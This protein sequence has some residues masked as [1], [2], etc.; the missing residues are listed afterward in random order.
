[1]PRSGFDLIHRE[2]KLA[3]TKALHFFAEVLLEIQPHHKSWDQGTQG[4]DSIT[5]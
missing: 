3:P 2:V 5:A 4:S 1:M